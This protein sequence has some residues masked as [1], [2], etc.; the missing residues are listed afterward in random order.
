MVSD[1]GTDRAEGGCPECG[2]ECALCID[3]GDCEAC[4]CCY[5]QDE[6]EC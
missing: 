1:L 5:Q 3:A 4:D 6:E 2:C